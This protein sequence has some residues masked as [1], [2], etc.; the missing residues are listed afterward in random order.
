MFLLKE[1][2]YVFVT[3]LNAYQKSYGFELSAEAFPL[4]RMLATGIRSR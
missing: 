2:Y 3:L 1:I 4:P